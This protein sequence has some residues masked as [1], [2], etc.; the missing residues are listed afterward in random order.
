MLKRTDGALAWHAAWH[1]DKVSHHHL[2]CDKLVLFRMFDGLASNWKNFRNRV[3]WLR[4]RKFN[5]KE[6]LDHHPCVYSLKYARMDPLWCLPLILFLLI[7]WCESFGG[8]HICGFFLW[9]TYLKVF[10]Y[11]FWTKSL[12]AGTGVDAL[13]GCF[14]STL[15]GRTWKIQT[16]LL[17]LDMCLLTTL[18]IQ[19]HISSKHLFHITIIQITM[20]WFIRQ[21]WRYG[22]QLS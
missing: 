9:S 15:H 22:S 17:W 12:H 16:D 10:T 6:K 13:W 4:F 5:H 20:W 1:M 11:L 18:L 8:D 3:T 19:C 2:L 14:H 7:S 21:L